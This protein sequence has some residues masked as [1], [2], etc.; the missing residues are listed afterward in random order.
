MYC[1]ITFCGGNDSYGNYLFF[2]FLI[3]HFVLHFIAGIF[4]LNRHFTLFAQFNKMT[5]CLEMMPN[6]TILNT[7]AF[8]LFI[9]FAFLNA[10]H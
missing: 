6:K 8:L 7:F 4:I 3:K 10:L 9:Y 5:D 1:L 2:F